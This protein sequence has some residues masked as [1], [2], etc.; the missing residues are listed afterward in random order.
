MATKSGNKGRYICK[1]GFYDIYAKDT[2]KP[3]K[4]SKYKFV[5]A[6]VK[7]TDYVVYHAK[8][9]IEKGLK[10]K[11]LAV[12]KAVELLGAKAQLYGL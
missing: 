3:K 4:E 8:K 1:V 7:A 11:D 9:V 6:D 12:T 5:K 2:L 10:T